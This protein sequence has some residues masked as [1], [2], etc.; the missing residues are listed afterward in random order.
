MQ[1]KRT[2]LDRFISS[3]TQAN[4]KDVRLLL[5][6]Q[7]ILV[8][9][10]VATDIHQPVDEFS[11]IRFDGE[12]LQANT[13]SY[14]M[15]NKPIGVVSA[16]KD[17]QHTTVIDLLH[18]PDSSHLHIA[19]RLDRFSSGLLLLTNDGRWSRRL[20]EPKFAVT[21]KYLV[22]VKNPITEDYIEAFAKGMFFA[23]ENITTRPAT[24]RIVNEHTAEICL[25]E[26][27]YHQ[28]KRMFGRF[29]N[30]VLTLHRTA[31]G[32]LTLDAA[33]SSG[34]HR[35]LTPAEVK[36]ISHPTLNAD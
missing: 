13:P 3:H 10:Q 31:I 5:A 19:G 25:T 8:D 23:Y 24:L 9:G 4:K 35:D 2:R 1:S 20:S 34:E 29:R 32:L 21:K 30:P 7:R 27:R 18:R 15:L 6:Q 36:T 16:T 14:I 22:T 33:L 26:G 28:I 12:V 17:A 11:H